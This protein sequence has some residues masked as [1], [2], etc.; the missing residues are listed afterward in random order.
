MEGLGIAH[1]AVLHC[2]LVDFLLMFGLP[3]GFQVLLLRRVHCKFVAHDVLQYQEVPGK[4]KQL[5]AILHCCKTGGQNVL[6]FLC[7]IW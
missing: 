3:L 4:T 6:T 5:A 7:G 1:F 2:T